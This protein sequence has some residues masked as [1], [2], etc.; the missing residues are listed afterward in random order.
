MAQF[1]QSPPPLGETT[2]PRTQ[3]CSM[4]VG[5]SAS[6]LG[7]L[8]ILHGAWNVSGVDPGS[9]RS[10]GLLEAQAWFTQETCSSRAH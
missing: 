5:E 9:T 8:R 1:V 2:N 6:H 10:R 3:K 7:L 4:Q